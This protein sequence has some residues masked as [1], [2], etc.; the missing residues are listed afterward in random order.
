MRTVQHKDNM[1]W[2]GWEEFRNLTT[3]CYL[4]VL[5]RAVLI[6]PGWLSPFTWRVGT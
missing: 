6:L 5:F 3:P 4:Y 1:G 2:S